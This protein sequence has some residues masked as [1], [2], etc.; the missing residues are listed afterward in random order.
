MI[1]AKQLKTLGSTSN[2]SHMGGGVNYK[3][4]DHNLIHADTMHLIMI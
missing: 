3:Y 1:S 4:S 2:A